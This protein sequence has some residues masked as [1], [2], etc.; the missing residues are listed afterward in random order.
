VQGKN[1]G[2]GRGVGEI[3]GGGSVNRR[4]VLRT[5]DL[6]FVNS[7]VEDDWEAIGGGGKRGALG[8][9]RQLREG[10]YCQEGNK[11]CRRR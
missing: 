11:S 4:R 1:K 10:G 8:V 2:Y 5:L 7:T 6:T 3:G 9:H